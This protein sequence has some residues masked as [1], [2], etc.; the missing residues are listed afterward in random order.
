M[1]SCN[2]DGHLMTNQAQSSFSFEE[3]RQRLIAQGAGYRAGAVHSKNCAIAGLRPEAIATGLIGHILGVARA[4]LKVG[5]TA[6]GSPGLDLQTVL[7]L[8]ASGAVALSKTSL[9]KPVTRGAAILGV[10]GALA[11]ALLKRRAARKAASQ[12]DARGPA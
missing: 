2:R 9:P 1:P 5:N 10:T 11:A 8:L 3:R 4:A 12:A 7:R 6:P